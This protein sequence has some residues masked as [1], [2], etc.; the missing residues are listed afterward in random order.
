MLDAYN[1]N[2]EYKMNLIAKC[3][4]KSHFRILAVL[5]YE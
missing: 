2:D 5:F 3:L 4:Y 1:T